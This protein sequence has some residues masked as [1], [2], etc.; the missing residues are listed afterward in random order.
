[1]QR[2]VKRGLMAAVTT[3]LVVGLGAGAAPQAKA[4]QQQK[5]I[6]LQAEEIAA[7]KKAQAEEV[8]DVKQRLLAIEALLL[9]AT[10]LRQCASA[11]HGLHWSRSQDT[12]LSG[13]LARPHS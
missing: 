2:T 9:R 12:R 11:S 7:L 8:A 6:E 10:K 1:M 13:R 3:A 5:L 4:Q